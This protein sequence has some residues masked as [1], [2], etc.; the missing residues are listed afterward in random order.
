VSSNGHIDFRALRIFVAVVESDTL[1]QAAK[2]LGITQSAVS[3]AIKQ[4]EAQTSS[5]LVIRSSKPVRLTA[6]G[7]I[8]KEYALRTL[9]DTQRVLSDIRVASTSAVLELNIGMIDSFGEV[10]SRQIM[11]RIKPFAAKLS[12]RTGI[13]G[14]LTEAL[15][16][17]DLDILITSDPLENHPELSRYPILRDPFV[18]I[19]PEAFCRDRDVTPQWL[20]QHVPF[21]HY[22][23]TIR[24]GMLVDL[25]A[26]RLNIALMTQYELDSTQTLLRFVQAGHGWSIVTGLC[27]I[28]HPELLRRTR[29]MPLANGANARHLS[30]LCHSR[31]LGN[32]PER[33]ARICQE[34]YGNDLIPK[35][36]RLAP[37]FKEQAYTIDELPPIA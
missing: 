14:A 8:F 35:L 21:V 10:A 33:L 6:C 16:D 1:T 26:R 31:E 9:A 23:R 28:R 27:L 24:I 15:L 34:I 19:V 37:W 13:S 7:K 17:H 22:S 25:I 3:Q 36:T 32:L 4:L 5:E 29:V 18:M 30:L 20:A 12:I 2:R 11:E